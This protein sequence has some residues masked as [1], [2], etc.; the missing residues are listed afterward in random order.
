M[1][2]PWELH[3]STWSAW[4]WWLHALAVYY[5]VGFLWFWARFQRAEHAVKRGDPGA[6]ERFNELLRGFPNTV[7]AKQFGK[8]PYEVQGPEQ[9]E[10]LP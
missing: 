10:G 5:V 3:P 6:A 4:V 1:A 7:Y 8:K 9:G 2:G